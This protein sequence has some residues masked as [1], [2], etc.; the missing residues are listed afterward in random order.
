MDAVVGV[1]LEYGGKG[2]PADWL[3]A[4]LAA[5]QHG[6][7]A[8]RQL[9]ALGVGSNG[10]DMRVAAGRLHR[11]HRG[12]YCVGHSLLSIKGHW[13]AAVLACGD[14]AIL[15]HRCAA[16]NF[17]I[18]AKPSGNIDVIALR[19]GRGRR[20]GIALHQVRRLRRIDCCFHD[21]IPTTTVAR[22]LFD[23]ASVLNPRQFRYAWEQAERLRLLDVRPVAEL[24]EGAT[25]HRGIGH[26]R[27]LIADRVMPP[28]T[29][30]GLERQFC[31][32][33][34]AY[35]F[36]RPL[37]NVAIGP[38]TVDALWPARRLIIELDS[39][40]FHDNTAAFERDRARDIDL[41]VWGYRVL[42][43]TAKRLREK[44]AAVATAIRSLLESA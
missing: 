34:D 16:A 36:D 10:V 1:F 14:G 33:C 2:R 12:V 26:L 6:V 4:E 32:F 21:A 29:N 17:G 27:A 31:D 18:L 44:P 41:Q 5:R 23:L 30:P 8:R 15:S 7:V 3:V 13:M 22:T 43:V 24:C 37:F 35:G 11:I 40:A 9:L 25:G 39:R 20:P 19:R 28:D 38:Y 42:R